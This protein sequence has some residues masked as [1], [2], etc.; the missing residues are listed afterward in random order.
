[1]SRTEYLLDVLLSGALPERAKLIT[2]CGKEVRNLERRMAEL[3]AGDAAGNKEH[4]R[5]R[6]A[7]PER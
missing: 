2:D 3:T 7:A 5:Q 6:R 4:G 1:M